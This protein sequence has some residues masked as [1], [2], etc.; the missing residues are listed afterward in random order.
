MRDVEQKDIQEFLRFAHQDKAAAGYSEQQALVVRD[1][2]IKSGFILEGLRLLSVKGVQTGTFDPN[3]P[4]E[5]YLGL[6]ASLLVTLFQ[7]GREFESWLLNRD[8]RASVQSL[9]RQQEPEPGAQGGQ[10]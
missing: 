1:A 8:L 5:F 7:F 3:K 6:G 2:L 10:R 4:D 9:E